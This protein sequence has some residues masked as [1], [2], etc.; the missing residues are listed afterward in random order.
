MTESRPVLRILGIRGIPAAHGGFETFAEKLAPYLVNRGWRVIVYCQEQG[1]AEPWHDTWQGVERF[2]IPVAGDGAAATMQFDLRSILHAR[3][4]PGLCLTLGYNTACFWPLLRVKGIRNVA[5]MDG[6]EWRRGKWSTPV[7]AWFWLNDW[8]GCFTAHHLIADH[9]EIEKLLRRRVHQKHITQI[10]Y[11]ADRIEDV[12]PDALG[13]LGLESGQY[14]TLIARAEPE[15]SV[16]EAVQ[17]FSMRPRGIKLA[18]LGNYAKD[19]AYHQ[20]VVE[21]AGE[22]VVFLGPIY[23]KD[24]VRAIRAHCLAYVHGHQVGGTNPSLVEALG[25]G[26]PV[27][28]HDNAFNRW[29]TDEGAA[30]FKTA[31]DADHAFTRLAKNLPLRLG[32]G[33]ASMETFEERFTWDGILGR[34][35]ATLKAEL[36]GGIVKAPRT[37]RPV[38]TARAAGI[39]VAAKLSPEPLPEL[40]T[41]EA[42]SYDRR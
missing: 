1:S 28:A 31:A 11:G 29:V 42:E 6:I 21:A 35:E 38:V 12:A 17:G 19:N 39:P 25:A 27:I 16:L 5:N 24:T 20:R 22:E 14:M 3:K 7:K 41:A 2:H 15:N 30:Y 18:V 10:A 4:S 13:A 34:Y 23:D 37:V 32:M 33:Q 8:I 26:N 40:E 36:V 9:P